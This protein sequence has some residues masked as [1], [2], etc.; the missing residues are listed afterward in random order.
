M[1]FQQLDERSRGE[2]ITLQD[3]QF[4]WSGNLRILCGGLLVLCF[5]FAAI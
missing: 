1:V 5:G 4:S 3:G 2:S